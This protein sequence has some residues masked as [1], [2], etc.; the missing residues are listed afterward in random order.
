[1]S[2]NINTDDKQHLDSANQFLNTSVQWA[3]LHT[4][5]STNHH[6]QAVVDGKSL[7]L[8]LNAADNLAFGV[9]RKV[10]ASILE[11]IQAYNWA[12]Q[13]IKNNWQEGWCL[14]LDH[15][16]VIE[17][18]QSHL[19][20]Q[21][22]GST[23]LNAVHEWQRIRFD[24]SLNNKGLFNYQDLFEKYRN[25]FKKTLNNTALQDNLRLTDDVENN[26]NDLPDIPNC[27]THHDLHL[28]NICKKDHQLVV[29]DWE[30]AGI[31]NPWFDAASLHSKFG[32]PDEDIAS[33]P[34]FKHLDNTQLKQGIA[35]TVEL[36]ETLETLWFA[37]RSSTLKIEI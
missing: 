1:M 4:S 5:G 6:F 34:A 26:L 9:S 8:R 3:P 14:M 16:A 30:Y 29:L 37:V 11:L 35:D 7:I 20:H 22:I 15:G 17:A 24:K 19:G 28:G 21:E 13:I 25:A 32:V 12:P 27:L 10:E 23:L 2:K 31:G 33:L 18:E 36:T